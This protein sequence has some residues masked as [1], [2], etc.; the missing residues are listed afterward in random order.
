MVAVL[1]YDFCIDGTAVKIR[2][3]GVKIY[4]QSAHIC[5]PL[6]K[7]ASASKQLI[8]ICDNCRLYK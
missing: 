7:F 4:A 6:S 8:Q 1:Q 3:Y 2:Q 5:I